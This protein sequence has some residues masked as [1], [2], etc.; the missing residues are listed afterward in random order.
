VL[1][2]KLDEY[3][4]LGCKGIA[5]HGFSHEL[6]IDAMRDLTDLCRERAVLSW[7]AYGMD[8]SDPE[9]KANRIG[10]VLASDLCDGVVLDA[11]GAWEDEASDVAKAHAFYT[12]FRTW[13]DRA[14]GKVV[15]DQPWPKP[16]VHW[17][18]FPWED[19]SACVDAHAPQDYYNDWKSNYGVDRYRKLVPI[20][21][22]AWTKLQ[23]RL[24]AEGL[25]RPRWSTIQGYGWDDIQADLAACLNL[26]ATMPLL[27][28]SEPFPS[29]SFM[30]VWG[31][32]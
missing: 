15:I 10:S 9:L 17:S 29:D 14:K 24:A 5:W 19:F 30:R 11:E 31:T 8:D 27:V 22:A 12:A 4:K 28:W 3:Y 6:N 18:R 13:R 32:R 7:A 26:S 23:V 1:R 20:F 16:T 2:T 21:N 25:K